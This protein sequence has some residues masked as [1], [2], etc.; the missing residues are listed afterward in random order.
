MDTVV[1]VIIGL[2]AG[3]IFGYVIAVLMMMSKV[4][5]LEFELIT[6]KE[7]KNQLNEIV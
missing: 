6:L 4:S 3:T 2:F 5:D 7:N 1:W